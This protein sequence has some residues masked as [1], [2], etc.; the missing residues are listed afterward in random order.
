MRLTE[1]LCS[2]VRCQTRSIEPQALFKL[3]SKAS[4]SCF[5]ECWNRASLKRA[6]SLHR[7][8]ISSFRL[9]WDKCSFALTSLSWMLIYYTNSLFL[10]ACRLPYCSLWL[11]FLICVASSLAVASWTRVLLWRNFLLGSISVLRRWLSL[12]L[13]FLLVL[14]Q[15]ELSGRRGKERSRRCCIINCSSNFSASVKHLSMTSVV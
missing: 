13:S 12:R 5:S 10:W 6:R 2:T 15:F 7:S 4:L 3:R 8:L 14:G 1:L 11:C 9:R